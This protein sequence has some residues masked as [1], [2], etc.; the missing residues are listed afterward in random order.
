MISINNFICIV[1][2]V[3][4]NN[5]RMNKLKKAG[6]QG[7]RLTIVLTFKCCCKNERIHV[8]R[9]RSSWKIV[10]INKY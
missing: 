1:L 2:S 9:I 7:M 8:K 5:I 3:V 10:V 4:Q 6:E